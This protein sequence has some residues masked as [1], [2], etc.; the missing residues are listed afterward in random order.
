[1]TSSITS[2]F[3]H[4]CLCIVVIDVQ[5][6]VFMLYKYLSI[7]SYVACLFLSLVSQAYFYLLCSI[8]TFYLL[9]HMS[10]FTSYIRCT[11]CGAGKL[12]PSNLLMYVN[13]CHFSLQ[14]V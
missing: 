1:M 9:C 7:Y 8:S 14:I 2:H 13:L 10:L 11:T 5:E 12:K 4:S 6:V 3:D